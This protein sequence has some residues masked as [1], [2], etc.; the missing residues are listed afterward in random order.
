MK[1]E[2]ALRLL[3]VAGFLLAVITIAVTFSD[4]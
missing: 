3:A 1:R 2:D 4:G